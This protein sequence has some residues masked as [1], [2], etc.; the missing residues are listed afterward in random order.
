VGQKD[1]YT[2]LGVAEDAS[3]EEI[4]KSYRRL[5]KEN[6]PDRNRDD[7][8]AEARF[9]EIQEAYD[10]LGDPE[11][12]KR[13]DQMRRF[14]AGGPGGA[15]GFRFEDLFGGAGGGG[16]GFGGSIFDIFERAGMGRSGVRT[17]PRKGE[18]L[19][20]TLRVPFR[21]AAFGGKSSIRVPRE[22]SCATCSG[23]GARPGTGA[24]TCSACGGTGAT[25]DAQ[26]AFAFSRP[27]PRCYGRG[28]VIADP[29]SD[30]RGSGTT[31]RTRTLEVK[32]PAG[33]EDGGRI[34][35]RGEGEA[36]SQGAPPGDLILTIR[37][38]RDDRFR[39]KGLDVESDLTVDMVT[40]ALGAEREVE[41]LH[42]PVSLKIPA[43]VQP[44]ARLRLKGRGVEDHR[45]RRGDHFVRVRVEVPKRLTER[46]RELL[47][48]FQ[49]EG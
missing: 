38:I 30:C 27:C 19:H 37:V 21:T 12:R 31:R 43:G 32:I 49:T 8:A 44:N 28:R 4:R 15:G 3:Q 2:V 1:Y 6:H 22:E 24:E 36:G 13:Y 20:Y 14:G 17:A 9:K 26:G 46:Q 45:G 7:P 29:C 10:V 18:D 41:T 47:A 16:G 35:L 23:T 25:S 40:A 42:G 48:E 5:A 11:K 33:V 39:R 34:R